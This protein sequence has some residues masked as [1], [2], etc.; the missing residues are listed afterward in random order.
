M[1]QMSRRERKLRSGL[2]VVGPTGLLRATDLSQESKPA[3]VDC[4]LSRYG[5]SIGAEVGEDMEEES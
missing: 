2:Q 5:N 3:A 4:K 1:D